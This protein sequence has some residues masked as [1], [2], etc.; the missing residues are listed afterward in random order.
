MKKALSKINTIEQS[1]PAPL[2][3][4]V[5]NYITRQITTGDWARD[6]QIPSE[7]N[8]VET[9]G[10]S[11]MTV[12]RALREL[13]AEGYLIR[14]QGVGTFVSPCKPQ[15]ALLEIRS[16]ADDIQ[17]RGGK[18][19]SRVHLLAEKK[20]PPDI[21]LQ[22]ELSAGQKIFHSIIVHSENGKPVQYS[23]RYVNPVVAPD[24]LN[25]N[26]ETITPSRYLLNIVPLTEAEHIIEAV[27]P[28]PQVQKLLDIKSDEPCLVLHRRTWLNEMV[29]TK[30]RFVYP[31]SRYRLGGRFKPSSGAAPL[32]A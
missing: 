1:Q 27:I 14:L 7:H 23:D 24:Y 17:Q 10:V 9:L 16:I 15:S 6:T 32:I 31:G 2:Y 22:M 12:N 18:H 11:R 20:A 26:F 28:E 4:K 25:Q 29:A 19:T 5:K 21:A 8:L 3:Q 30:S 13:T